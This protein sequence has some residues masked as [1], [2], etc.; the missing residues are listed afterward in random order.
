MPLTP[1]AMTD[2]IE[3]AYKKEW[4]KKKPDPLPDAGKDDRRLIF[5]GVARG[6]LEYLAA[7]PTEILTTIKTKDEAGTE[8]KFQVSETDFNINA[9]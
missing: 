3:S 7:N 9:G 1:D 8:I 5:A 4:Q 6:I 2:A